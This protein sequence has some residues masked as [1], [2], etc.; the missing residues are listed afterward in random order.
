MV[1]DLWWCCR[2]WVVVGFVGVGL[3]VL[4]GVAVGVAGVGLFVR[5]LVE[6]CWLCRGCDC[7]VVGVV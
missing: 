7:L 4:F 3:V 1:V 5:H 2:A 6:A